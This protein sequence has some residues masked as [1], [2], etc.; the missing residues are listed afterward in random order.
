MSCNFF[1]DIL[2]LPKIFFQM[3]AELYQPIHGLLLDC[4]R[5]TE[6]TYIIAE[7]EE[8]NELNWL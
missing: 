4:P 2:K 7:V 5:N 8:K 1:K 3:W 6:N